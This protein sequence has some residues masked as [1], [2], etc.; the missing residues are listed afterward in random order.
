[1]TKHWLAEA[2]N[3]DESGEDSLNDLIVKRIV[4]ACAPKLGVGVV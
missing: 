2:F 4:S 3:S 1:M